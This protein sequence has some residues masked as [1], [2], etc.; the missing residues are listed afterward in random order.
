VTTATKAKVSYTP[1]DWTAVI[2]GST[3]LLMGVAPGD[4]LVRSVWEL[5]SQDAEVPVILD[6]LLAHGISRLPSFALAGLASG[7][8][9][10]V[11][12]GDAA[13]QVNTAAGESR[14]DGRGLATWAELSLPNDIAR[15]TLV[16][17]EPRGSG[18]L[19]GGSGVVLASAL[20]VT[21]ESAPVPTAPSYDEPRAVDVVPP[22]QPVVVAVPEQSVAPELL[23][24]EA[25]DEAVDEQAVMGEP[26]VEV[27]AA[28]PAYDF[29]F[30]ATQFRTVE[31]AA[32]REE[33]PEDAPT[34][35]PAGANSS[36]PAAEEQDAVDGATVRRDQVVELASGPGGGGGDTV[37]AV[38]C[39]A[40][41]ANPPGSAQ[42][43]ICRVA[44]P[45]QESIAVPRPT[46]GVLRLSNGD[47]VNV[48]RDILLGRN[49]H[50]E[51]SAGSVRPHV[52]Q[53]ASPAGDVSRNH[54]RVTLDGWSVLVT[55][56]GSTNG[57][58]V[59][60]PG[61]SSEQLTPGQPAPIVPGTVVTLA[62][63]V[64]FTFDVT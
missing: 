45:R 48:D 2:G 11:A 47:T 18:A 27:E 29:L 34:E 1:G 41:H 62:D 40:G 10:V 9:H 55:D 31:D 12:R 26:V 20:D 23:V 53:L 32:V 3:W 25:V 13:V 5:A 42:C 51:S 35:T 4:G 15:L 39:P 50:L 19:P 54:V 33:T 44:I 64:F 60:A 37:L 30:Q 52:I 36:E 63:T 21:W 49:P 28:A 58:V 22:V 57:T 59:T 17:P 14:L 56:L 43:R 16:G 8:W 46:L 24:D 6:A 7:A 61:G 38:G